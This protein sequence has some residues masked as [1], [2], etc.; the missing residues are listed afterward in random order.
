MF[1]VE[2]DKEF[3]VLKLVLFMALM[4]L[5]VEM[6][7]VITGFFS[8]DLQGAVGTLL[9]FATFIIMFFVIERF[10]RHGVRF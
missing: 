3:E 4:L 8:S 1:V 9:F 2:K 10:L 7:P 5:I 6:S